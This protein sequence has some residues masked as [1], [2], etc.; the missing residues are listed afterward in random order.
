MQIF[1]FRNFFFLVLKDFS[2]KTY[3]RTCRFYN[4]FPKYNSNWACLPSFTLWIFFSKIWWPSQFNGYFFR[5]PPLLRENLWK[6]LQFL[7]LIFK[8]SIM[9][10]TFKKIC[11]LEICSKK[12]AALSKCLQ[13]IIHF[14]NFEQ[15]L[16]HF[17]FTSL[18][19]LVMEIFFEKKNETCFN[20]LIKALLFQ[21]LW[22]IFWTN[23]MKNSSTLVMYC[24][25]SFPFLHYHAV[26]WRPHFH[27]KNDRGFNVANKL[28]F[29][30]KSIFFTP[31]F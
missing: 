21:E 8:Y 28:L 12:M 30:S 16:Q 2:G 11:P 6:D 25:S 9:I 18:Q 17:G 3:E 7:W 23:I 13:F 31:C 29:I 24:S 1:H 26:L 10:Y 22:T 27:N 19:N 20:M 15:H 5:F 14:H 4:A